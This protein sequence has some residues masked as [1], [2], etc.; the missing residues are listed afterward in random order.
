[1]SQHKLLYIGI[2]A[3]LVTGVVCVGVWSQYTKVTEAD[4]EKSEDD[5]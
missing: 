1:M 5:E 4:D 3:A 2:A